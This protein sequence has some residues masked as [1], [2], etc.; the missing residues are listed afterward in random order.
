LNNLYLPEKNTP[1]LSDAISS[2]KRKGI[3]IYLNF[4]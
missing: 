2:I 3:T 1:Q 4:Q